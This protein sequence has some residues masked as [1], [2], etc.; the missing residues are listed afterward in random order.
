[1]RARCDA[2]TSRTRQLRWN[3]G[4][5]TGPPLRPGTVL[6]SR[7]GRRSEHVNQDK[8]DSQSRWRTLERTLNAVSATTAASAASRMPVTANQLTPDELMVSI[9]SR[10]AVT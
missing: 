2:E 7:A 5:L 1:M 6:L 8:G 4:P 9:R 3:P 10:V